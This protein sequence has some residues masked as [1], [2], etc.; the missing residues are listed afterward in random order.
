[1]KAVQNKSILIPLPKLKNEIHF[2]ELMKMLV[3]YEYKM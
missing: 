1:M 3:M 2:S